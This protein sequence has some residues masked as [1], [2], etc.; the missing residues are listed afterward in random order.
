MEQLEINIQ[1]HEKIVN[2]KIK[3]ELTLKNAKEI[4]LYTFPEERL[5]SPHPIYY[6]T[7]LVFIR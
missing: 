6:L 2:K 3:E 7:S 5:F 1:G 4:C